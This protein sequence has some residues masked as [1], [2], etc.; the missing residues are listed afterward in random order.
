MRSQLLLLSHCWQQT[1][2]CYSH[3]V[4]SRP[5]VATLTVDS[6]PISATLT[7]DS[8]PIFAT[9]T[10]FPVWPSVVFHGL[11][12]TSFICGC[13][14]GCCQERFPSVWLRNSVIL[15]ACVF[16]VYS[17]S[18]VTS[19]GDARVS[20]MITGDLRTW[21]G[22]DWTET[23]CHKIQWRFV[24]WLWR[25]LDIRNKKEVSSDRW[26]LWAV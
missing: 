21:T 18:Y 17:V 12:L 14:W 24:F 13:L 6:R 2:R 20:D 1:Y 15:T 22:L 8:R 16:M 4:D 23:A 10:L 25:T 7:V 11:P 5:I 19:A 26:K 3:T 9:V